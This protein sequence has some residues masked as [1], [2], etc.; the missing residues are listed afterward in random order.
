MTKSNEI[1]NISIKLAVWKSILS[2]FYIIP[3]GIILLIIGNIVDFI[4]VDLLYLNENYFLYK[5]LNFVS[6][7]LFATPFTLLVLM[8]HVALLVSCTLVSSAFYYQSKHMNY[9][10]SAFFHFIIW[11]LLGYGML[12][13][14]VF[15]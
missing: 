14:Y 13:I 9:Y 1:Q 2:I 7:S 5:A 11:I 8:P 10:K 15:S 3:I 12:L 4:L 6:L